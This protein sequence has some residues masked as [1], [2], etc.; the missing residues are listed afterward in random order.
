M[1]NMADSRQS[2]NLA[3]EIGLYRIALVVNG[4]FKQMRNHPAFATLFQG[5]E[6]HDDEACLTYL[7][8]VVLGGRKLSDLDSEVIRGCAWMGISPTLCRE[9]LALFRRTAPPIIGAA[10]TDAWMLRAAPLAYEFPVIADDDAV[11]A[12]QGGHATST[13]SKKTGS[14]S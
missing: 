10:L 7:W 5:S 8:W 1:S 12:A 14:S 4:V 6:S 13:R 2:T 3:L 9:W 11:Q